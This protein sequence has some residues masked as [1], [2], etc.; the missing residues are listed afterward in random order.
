M[1]K[2]FGPIDKLDL[3]L[4]C[5]A[6]AYSPWY[7]PL[8]ARRI[9]DEDPST[10]KHFLILNRQRLVLRYFVPRPTPTVVTTPL[11][12]SCLSSGSDAAPSQNFLL[13]MQKKQRVYYGRDVQD[14]RNMRHNNSVHA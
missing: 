6:Q 9:D 14:K 2:T 13:L 7:F 8:V 3:N 4:C 11:W 1:P 10:F 5:S 12:L